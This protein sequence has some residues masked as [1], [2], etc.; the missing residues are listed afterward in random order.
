VEG[1]KPLVFLRAPFYDLGKL[2]LNTF[3]ELNP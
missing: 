2:K 1:I 3:S